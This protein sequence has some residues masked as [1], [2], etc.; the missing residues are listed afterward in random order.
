MNEIQF[1]DFLYLFL[2]DIYFPVTFG[3]SVS[4]IEYWNN[5][6]NIEYTVKL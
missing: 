6:Y 3:M 4:I 1:S 2:L 5:D